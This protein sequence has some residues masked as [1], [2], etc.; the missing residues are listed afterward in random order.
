[1]WPWTNEVGRDRIAM[2]RCG[3]GAKQAHVSRRRGS[4]LESCPSAQRPRLRGPADRNGDARP[5][6]STCERW[7]SGLK[8]TRLEADREGLPLNPMNEGRPHPFKSD[9]RASS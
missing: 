2:I 8:L 4:R 3:R 6:R 7:L 5:E 1:M 9:T